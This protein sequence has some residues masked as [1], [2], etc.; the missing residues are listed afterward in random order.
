[1]MDYGQQDLNNEP[2]DPGHLADNNWN[3]HF[4]SADPAGSLFLSIKRPIKKA[5][6]VSL[7]S[8]IIRLQVCPIITRYSSRRW[9]FFWNA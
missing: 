6:V 2:L 5:T 8:A 7:K 1:M 3:V 4:P 9:V